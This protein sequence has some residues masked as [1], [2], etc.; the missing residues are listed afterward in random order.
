MKHN[1]T[2]SITT[3]SKANSP[4]T[5]GTY[6]GTDATRA[7]SVFNEAIT[8]DTTRKATLFVDNTIIREYENKGHVEPT[9]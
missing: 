1:Y 7:M 8:S 5:G 4:C 3:L 9:A 6:Y 2:V